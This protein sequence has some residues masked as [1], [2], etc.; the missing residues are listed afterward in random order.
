MPEDDVRAIAAF[1]ASIKLPS[2]LPPVDESEFDAFK[3]LQASK[4]VLNIAR[5]PGDA[6]A[7]QRLYH[8]ECDGCH[9]QAAEGNAAQLIPPLVG[10]HSLYLLRLVE[11]FRKG[12]RVHDAPR[13]A[14]IF[15][16]FSDT[17]IGDIL[18][19]LSTLDDT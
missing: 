2:K 9:G 4:R 5:Y 12:E 6:V 15:Q 1:L 3:R 7:G 13:D 16:A 11:R 17:E 18:A 14:A 8:K 19:W 10:Q